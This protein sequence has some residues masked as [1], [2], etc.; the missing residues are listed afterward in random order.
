MM[1]VISF[2]SIPHSIARNFGLC[3]DNFVIESSVR[4]AE[5]PVLHCRSSYAPMASDPCTRLSPRSDPR[6]CRE[7]C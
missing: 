2:F 1:R 7:D 5:R 6:R 3:L 4:F